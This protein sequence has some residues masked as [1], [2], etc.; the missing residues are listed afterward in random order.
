MP[1]ASKSSTHYQRYLCIKAHLTISGHSQICLK[2]FFLF[3]QASK[4]TRDE[5]LELPPFLGHLCG[6]SYYHPELSR[7]PGMSE[8][9]KV[10][11]CYLGL[12][13]FLWTYFL[14]RLLFGPTET[15]GLA[16]CGDVTSRLS[17]F[18]VIPWGWG[19]SKKVDPWFKP[20][21]KNALG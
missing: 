6:H 5:W 8:C 15:T 3:V 9:F 12:K 20:N 7:C 1:R 17:L 11:Y 14:S 10:H 18:L 4:S 19:F 13:V 2:F 21:T 16:N